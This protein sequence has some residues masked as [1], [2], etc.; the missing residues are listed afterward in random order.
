MSIQTVGL[1]HMTLDIRQ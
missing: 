1:C